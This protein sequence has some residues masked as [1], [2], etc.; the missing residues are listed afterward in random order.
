MN[1]CPQQL[2]DN[3]ATHTIVELFAL[4]VDRT[5]HVLNIAG[6]PA[7]QF[8]VQIRI[9]PDQSYYAGYV[10]HISF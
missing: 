10:I 2:V 4:F 8:A 9:A 6:A 1:A 3:G 7:Q 5:K